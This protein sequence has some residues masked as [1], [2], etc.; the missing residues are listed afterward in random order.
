MMLIYNIIYHYLHIYIYIYVCVC[1]TIWLFNIAMENPLDVEVLMG[2][3]FVNG[4]FSIAM[5]M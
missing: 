3:S 2:N 1:V 5:L 4:P